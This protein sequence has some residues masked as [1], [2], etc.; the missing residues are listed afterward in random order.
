MGSFQV[1]CW[2]IE[3]KWCLIKFKYNGKQVKPLKPSKKDLTT[4]QK[5]KTKTQTNYNFDVSVF[6]I[7]DRNFIMSKQKGYGYEIIWG[8]WIWKW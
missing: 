2:I 6:D 3:E 5:G 1:R 4:K 8:D 7:L